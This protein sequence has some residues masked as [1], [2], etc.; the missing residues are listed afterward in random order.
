MKGKFG[1][2][3]KI[4][5]Y[6]AI[7]CLQNFI[8]HSMSLLT[9]KFAKSCHIEARIYLIFLKTSLNKLE[10]LLIPNFGLIGRIE[11]AVTE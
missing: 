9:V 1:K 6:Y 11:K 4:L 5:K 2:H 7:E 10:M 3:Q 8:L